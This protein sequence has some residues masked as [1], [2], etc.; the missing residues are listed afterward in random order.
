MFPVALAK[1]CPEKQNRP[2][3]FFR[4]LAVLFLAEEGMC[5]EESESRRRWHGAVAGIKYMLML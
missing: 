3:F 2:A 1:S 5:G 4:G